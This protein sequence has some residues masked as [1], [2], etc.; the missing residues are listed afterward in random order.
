MRID[1]TVTMCRKE[2]YFNFIIYFI[3]SFIITYVIKD[4]Y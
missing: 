2:L 4:I 3:I 1:H